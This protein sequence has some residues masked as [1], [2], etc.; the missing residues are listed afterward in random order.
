MEASQDKCKNV[1]SIK[2]PIELFARNLPRPMYS[3]M[4][5]L[6]YYCQK[7]NS[8]RDCFATN[9]GKLYFTVKMCKNCS[10]YNKIVQEAG[11]SVL[12][13]QINEQ[14]QNYLKMHD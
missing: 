2:P 5:Q 12:N 14:K 8:E 1:R 10:E 4:I 9:S 11:F 7:C 6:C 3:F 13:H